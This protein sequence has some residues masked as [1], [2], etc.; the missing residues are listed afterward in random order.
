MHFGTCAYVT[1]FKHTHCKGTTARS[2]LLAFEVQL[3][4]T[5]YKEDGKAECNCAYTAFCGD[6]WMYNSHLQ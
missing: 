2:E 5:W 1:H 4:G 6:T 3:L